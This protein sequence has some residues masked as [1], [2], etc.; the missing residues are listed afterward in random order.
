MYVYVCLDP[1]VISTYVFGH[2]GQMDLFLLII[3]SIRK[4]RV[5]TVLSFVERTLAATGCL[6][7]VYSIIIHILYFYI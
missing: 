4:L 6:G 2:G 3:F 1:V 5:I 7:Y